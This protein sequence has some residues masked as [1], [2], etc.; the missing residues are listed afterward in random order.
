MLLRKHDQRK[1]NILLTRNV[2]IRNTYSNHI[3]EDFAMKKIDR[4]ENGNRKYSLGF[5][6]FV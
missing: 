3:Y 2:I 5:R 6:M 1:N 4:I